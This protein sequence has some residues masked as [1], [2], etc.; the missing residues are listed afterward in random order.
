MCPGRLLC[1]GLNA[2]LRRVTRSHES[3]KSLPGTPSPCVCPECGPYLWAAAGYQLL[4][5]G[6]TVQSPRGSTFSLAC[7][8]PSLSGR[9]WQGP[10][11]PTYVCLLFLDKHGSVS[12]VF[13]RT[14]LTPSS[15]QSQLSSRRPGLLD[16]SLCCQGW[17]HGREEGHCHQWPVASCCPSPPRQSP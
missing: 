2:P 15:S 10:L 9:S 3:T 14:F 17:E 12:L 1:S 11:L 5:S 13:N 6:L 4:A 8:R 7:S 16:L